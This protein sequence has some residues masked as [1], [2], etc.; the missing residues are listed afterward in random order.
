MSITV[1]WDNNEKTII[2][3]TYVG[4]WTW[5]EF[6]ASCEEF[7]LLAQTVPHTVHMLIDMR[8]AGPLP[9]GAL[10]HIGA[11]NRLPPNMGRIVAVGVGSFVMRMFNVA[12]AVRPA[13]KERILIVA[14]LDEAYSHLKE[15]RVG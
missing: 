10:S 13:V 9:G 1:D 4:K 7:A 14:T 15:S 5:D 6:Y 8:H 11:L 2:R 3:Q 12:A